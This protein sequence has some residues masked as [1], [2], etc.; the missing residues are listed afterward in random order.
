M[1]CVGEDWEGD[2]LH[3]MTLIFS[4]RR[5]L[6]INAH[7]YLYFGGAKGGQESTWSMSR[8]LYRMS[9]FEDDHDVNINFISEVKLLGGQFPQIQSSAGFYVS[10]QNCLF[11]WDGLNLS[12]F[13]MSIELY[14]VKL[15]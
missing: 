1:I 5:T 8:N 4:T 15:N 11:V 10:V 9:F 2:V 7:T 3:L 13:S 12:C 14:T 6:M